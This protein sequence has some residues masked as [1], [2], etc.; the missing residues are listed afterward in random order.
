MI[1]VL[2]CLLDRWNPETD[3]FIHEPNYKL[4]RARHPDA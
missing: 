4:R 2:M 1:L 3:E